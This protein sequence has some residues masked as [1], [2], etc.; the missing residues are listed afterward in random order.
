MGK[1]LNRLN[2]YYNQLLIT[3]RGIHSVNDKMD[4]PIMAIT[5]PRINIS[6]YYHSSHQPNEHLLRLCIRETSSPRRRSSLS[7][8]LAWTRGPLDRLTEILRIVQTTAGWLLYGFILFI[9]GI[10]MG[11][12]YSILYWGVSQ[13]EFLSTSLLLRWCLQ[14]RVYGG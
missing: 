12:Y 1:R 9:Y 4:N 2:L 7:C 3:I 10:Y 6:T 8:S 5:T 14:T 11:L 13:S